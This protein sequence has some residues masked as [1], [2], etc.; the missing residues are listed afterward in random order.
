M[1][2]LEHRKG[3]VERFMKFLK[4]HRGLIL[5]FITIV[6]LAVLWCDFVEKTND[7]MNEVKTI[8]RS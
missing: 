3:K 8:E 6:V 7:Q 2:L 5:F 4:E 1:I